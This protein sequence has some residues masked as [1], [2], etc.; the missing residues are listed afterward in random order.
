MATESETTDYLRRV[1]RQWADDP[2]ATRN[3]DA[4]TFD[5]RAAADEI[6]R[7]GRIEKAALAWRDACDTEKQNRFRSRVNINAKRDLGAVQDAL[8]RLAN[9]LPRRPKAGCATDDQ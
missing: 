8:H 9:I 4:L 7:L 5:L 2:G 1:L 3:S 6:E